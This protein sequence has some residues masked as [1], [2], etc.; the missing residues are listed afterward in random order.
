[1]K[2]PD[3]TRH[4]TS[5]FQGHIGSWFAQKMLAAG[6]LLLDWHTTGGMQSMIRGYHR[7]GS[8][9]IL[10]DFQHSCKRD[11]L[12]WKGTIFLKGSFIFQPGFFRGTSL[13]FRMAFFFD[14]SRLG[15]WLSFAQR[16]W[17][18][19]HGDPSLHFSTT[20]SPGEWI[21]Y[22]RQISPYD[23]SSQRQISSAVSSKG[24]GS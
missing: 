12:P 20:K 13:V 18:I 5:G 14:L 21:S 6:S 15:E 16:S 19:A 1:M 4:L 17:T 3:F 10:Q 23:W 7:K 9:N 2:S 24:R 8:G 22:Q 11:C